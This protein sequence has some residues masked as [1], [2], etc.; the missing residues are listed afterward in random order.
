MCPFRFHAGQR[1]LQLQ[2]QNDHPRDP[3][4]LLQAASAT[5]VT[6]PFV[7][8]IGEK[9]ASPIVFTSD[10]EDRDATRIR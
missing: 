6:K 2:Q 3:E 4:Q 7:A 8:E 10:P 1:A 9:L 5:G